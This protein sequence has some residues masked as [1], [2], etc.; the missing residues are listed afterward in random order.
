MKTIIN[1]KADKETKRQA[2]EVARELGVPLSTVIN[3]YLKQFVRSRQVVLSS[4][5]RMTPALEALIGRVEADI[6]AGRNIS[7]VF[8]SAEAMD[9]F[10]DAV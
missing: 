3:A 8:S 4:V 10:L 5:P 2:Q 1:I 9:E 6:K 7:P